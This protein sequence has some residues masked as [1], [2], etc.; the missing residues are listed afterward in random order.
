M[1]R[2]RRRR[3]CCLRRSDQARLNWQR[4]GCGTIEGMGRAGRGYPEPK[5]AKSQRGWV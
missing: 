1:G 4:G 2:S 3:W 5:P